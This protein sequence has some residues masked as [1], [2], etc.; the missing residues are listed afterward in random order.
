MTQ[1]NLTTD[2]VR[3]HLLNKFTD[4]AELIKEYTAEAEHQEGEEVWQV[5]YGNDLDT[6]ETDFKLYR[7]NSANPSGG[8]AP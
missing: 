1:L 4:D 6:I 3:D 5:M 2:Y 7:E 8:V